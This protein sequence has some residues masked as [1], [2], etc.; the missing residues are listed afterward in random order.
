MIIERLTCARYSIPFRAPLKT[1]R[2]ELKSRRGFLIAAHGPD[3][4]VGVGEIAT[5]PEFG[6]E[7]YRAAESFLQGLPRD[8]LRSG[9]FPDIMDFARFHSGPAFQRFL[10]SASHPA[11]TF[12]ISCALLGLM[13]AYECPGQHS[14]AN[15]IDCTSPFSVNS[16]IFGFSA[17]EVFDLA[18]Q[19]YAVGFNT[20][21]LKVGVLPV[22][23]EL[24]AI[25]RIRVALPEVKLR[26][27][28]NRA[29]TRTEAVDFCTKV[30]PMG[31]EYIEDPT[32]NTDALQAL[33][34]H[35]D[36][37][38]AI[39][40]LWTPEYILSGQADWKLCDVLVLKPVR[41][42]SH[43]LI[44]KIQSA[45]QSHGVRTVYTTMFDTSIGI[46]C[47]LG[48]MR[49]IADHNI[50]HGLDTA[51][52]LASDTLTHPIIPDQGMLHVPDLA[53]LPGLIR[54]P[55]RTALGLPS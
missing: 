2:G 14:G 19:R 30:E 38:V 1:A 29:W 48:L 6:T 24:R 49:E 12:G 23:E 21:K 52:L 13:R 54:E 26:L 44:K 55:Y 47:T 28:A 20:L 11:V 33:R 31:I 37:R 53:S 27:D 18:Q 25:R 22:E 16:L 39:D 50:A 34:A 35:S 5:L 45:A 43:T 42:G 46:A 3:G 9:F 32:S 36:I 40:E 8:I 10:K 7:S 4:A 51:R 15:I 41:I 17:D